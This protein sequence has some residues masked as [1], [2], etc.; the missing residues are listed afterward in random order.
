MGIAGMGRDSPSMS[1]ISTVTPVPSSFIT[2]RFTLWLGPWAVVSVSAVPGSTFTGPAW[3]RIAPLA[4][5]LTPLG[6]LTV[7][8][9]FIRLPPLFTVRSRV[10]VGIVPAINSTVTST[11]VPAGI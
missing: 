10:Y 7:A 8:L 4:L 9:L 5:R 3:L 6:M 1:G 2:A 11:S